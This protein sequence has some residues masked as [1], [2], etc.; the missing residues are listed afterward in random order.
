MGAPPPRST[1]SPARWIIPVAIGS[2]III[3]LV[4]FLVGSN[5]ITQSRHA[6]ATATSIAHETATGNAYAATITSEQT[7][8]VVSANATSTALAVAERQPYH[9]A[10][11]GICDK[12]GATWG[13]IGV[14]TMNCASGELVLNTTSTQYEGEV[15]FSSYGAFTLASDA[16]VEVTVR[17][18][19]TC[20]GIILRK[21]ASTSGGY[22]FLI[23]N[24]GSW[25]LIRYAATDGTPTG[26]DSGSVT[27][28]TSYHIQAIAIGSTLTF[29]ADGQSL[30]SLTDKTYTTNDHIGLIEGA[31]G[32]SGPAYFSNFTFTPLS[33][34]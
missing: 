20:G 19:T 23:C 14:T 22:S 34:T 28:R 29:I 13:A 33:H 25:D 5:I 3:I 11:P 6:A 8:V 10:V 16:K 9:A 17:T 32:D 26:L 21:P 15:D 12:G 1:S 30:S 31:T 4:T 18:P 7:Q 24:D 27:A 2:A